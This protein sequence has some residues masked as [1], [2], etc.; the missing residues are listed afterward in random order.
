MRPVA[1]SHYRP[2]TDVALSDG[3][4]IDDYPAME[5]NHVS[6]GLK[7]KEGGTAFHEKVRKV[8][9]APKPDADGKD[10]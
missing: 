2:N 1:K 4:K 7:C 6:R 9:T 8:A 5:T 10:D 3:R